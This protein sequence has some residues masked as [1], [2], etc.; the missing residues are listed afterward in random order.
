MWHEVLHWNISA[1]VQNQYF[2]LRNS[3]GSCLDTHLYLISCLQATFGEAFKDTRPWK[4][5]DAAIRVA[6]DAGNSL[7]VIANFQRHPRCRDERNGYFVCELCRVIPSAERLHV[8]PGKASCLSCGERY[9]PEHFT[10]HHASCNPEIKGD[11]KVHDQA[12][13]RRAEKAAAPKICRCNLAGGCTGRQPPYYGQ[14]ETCD[15]CCVLDQKQHA[16]KKP[17]RRGT[18]TAA[19]KLKAKE[20]KLK[21]AT[22][23]AAFQEAEDLLRADTATNREWFVCNLPRCHPQKKHTVGHSRHACCAEP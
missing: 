21:R 18:K 7:Q 10:E 4:M 11:I 9:C 20:A 1:V 13:I 3:I 22:D 12:F 6:Q 5:L 8:G 14:F 17:G 19:E 16:S 2:L 23:L 15:S